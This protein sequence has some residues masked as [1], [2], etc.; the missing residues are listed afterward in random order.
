MTEAVMRQEEFERFRRDTES[1][2]RQ[3]FQDLIAMETAIFARIT[4]TARWFV[5]ITI[6]VSLTLVLSFLGHYVSMEMAQ[7]GELDAINASFHE[8]RRQQALTALT[9]DNAV[10]V[11]VLADKQIN[12]DLES[13]AKSTKEQ[14]SRTYAELESL[15]RPMAGD[16]SVGRG[17][18]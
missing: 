15:K 13:L 4:V 1:T 6:T 18:L 17:T 16:P 9:V 2:Q 14:V 5:G 8:L 3:L 12:K 11:L 10:R 7:E